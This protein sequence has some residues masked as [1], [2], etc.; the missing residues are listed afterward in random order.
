MS[1][2][3]QSTSTTQ[4]RTAACLLPIESPAMALDLAVLPIPYLSLW[5]MFAF[6]YPA[7]CPGGWALP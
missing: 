4:A 1:V 3:H 5:S 7:M 2:H 6:L